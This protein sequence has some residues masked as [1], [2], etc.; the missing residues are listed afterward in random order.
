MVALILLLVAEGLGL[1]V[2]QAR[3]AKNRAGAAANGRRLG[4]YINT[5]GGSPFRRMAR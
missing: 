4:R 5:V 2:V 3:K 1:V